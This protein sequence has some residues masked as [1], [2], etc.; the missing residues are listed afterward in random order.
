MKYDT[1]ISYEDFLALT[2]AKDN[3]HTWKDWKIDYCHMSEREAIKASYTEYQPIKNNCWQQNKRMIYYNRRV[4]NNHM[5]SV[6]HTNGREQI[7]W[8]N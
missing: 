1:I 5:K 4:K 8:L 3:R 7:K 2:G 6:F